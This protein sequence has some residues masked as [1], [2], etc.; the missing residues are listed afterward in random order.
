MTKPRK[1][2]RSPPK[3]LAPEV[4]E[5]TARMAVELTKSLNIPAA[6]AGGYAMQIYGSPRLTGDVEL[7]AA[8]APADLKPLKNVTLLT[9]GGRRYLTVDNVELDLIKR[10][11][12]L[13]DLYDA[14]LNSAVATEDGLP[15]V[16]PDYLAVIKF[17]AGRPKDED[18][19][20]WLL[21]QPDLVDRKKAL[22]IAERYLGGRFARDSFKSFVDEADWRTEREKRSP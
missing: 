21:Q 3:F 20:V 10:S 17:A 6:V 19:L 11:D 16:A 5:A 12:H 13:K 8:D 1:Y 4:L 22:D 2:K 14:A 15:I 18:D 7:I 9:F